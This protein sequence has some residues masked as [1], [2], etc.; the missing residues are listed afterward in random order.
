VTSDPAGAALAV[1]VADVAARAGRRTL[2]LDLSGASQGPP[3]MPDDNEVVPEADPG[4]RQFDL[5][6][7]Q[8]GED[9]RAAYNNPT[10]VRKG[11]DGLLERYDVLIV[12]GAGLLEGGDR[13]NMVAVCAATDG[14]ILVCP[15]GEVGV[16]DVQRAVQ[17]LHGAGA[18]VVGT[19]LDDRANPLLADDVARVVSRALAFAPGLGARVAGRIRRSSLLR[20]PLFP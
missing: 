19:V 3:W 10:R 1:E 12:H 11:L 6:S 4:G 16:P 18:K 15:T 9:P 2:V 8:C 13:I 20:A 14:A 7:A 5:L 17:L